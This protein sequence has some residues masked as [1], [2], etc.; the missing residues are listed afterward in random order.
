MYNKVIKDT[1]ATSAAAH[2]NAS[3]MRLPGPRKS[4]ESAATANAARTTVIE[5]AVKRK[6]E[7]ERRATDPARQRRR[8]SGGTGIL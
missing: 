3:R 2:G 6:Q 7:C 1:T 4:A 8:T 5:Q